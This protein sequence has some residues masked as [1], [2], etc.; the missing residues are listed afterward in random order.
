[1]RTSSDE[2]PGVLY[3]IVDDTP[4]S[5]R[6]QLEGACLARDVAYLEVD[7]RRFD[8]ARWAPL[9]A[10]SMLYCAATSQAGVVVEQLLAGPGVAT[11]YRHPLGAHILYDNQ[12]L[13]LARCGVPTPRTIYTLTSRR[14]ALRD[15]VEWLG[16]FPVILKIPGGSLGV[17]VVR[18]DSWPT[19][20]AVVD[21]VHATH[22]EDAC[23]MTCIE[24]AR[25]WRV[26]V[27][28]D[29]VACAYL[30]APM[31][32]DF[33]TF[34]DESRRE[35]FEAPAPPEVLAAALDATA[36]LGLEMGGVDVL[37]HEQGRAYVL[38][39]NFPCYFGHPL[40]AAGI[41]VAGAMVE[42]LLAKARALCP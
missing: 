7:A 40:E 39:V 32:D 24:P 38:E 6:E 15:Q 37:E 1:M 18:L 34:V 4:P 25:H 19:L 9:E 8:H 14:Q 23:L 2:A 22:G 10:G 11:F 26:I 17:G 13:F 21:M 30:N 12:T 3:V 27:I 35:D 42:H 5:T 20:F 28:G 36:A 41:D 33:R 29:E 16:G 31:E